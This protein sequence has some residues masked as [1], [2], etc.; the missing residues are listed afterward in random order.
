MIDAHVSQ[1]AT[2]V[3]IGCFDHRVYVTHHVFWTPQQWNA[4]MSTK[5]E[6]D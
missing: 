3:E 1:L 6:T 4:A 2:G 5:K